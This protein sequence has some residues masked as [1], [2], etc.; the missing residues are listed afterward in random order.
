VCQNPCSSPRQNMSK[1]L[2]FFATAVHDG[3]ERSKFGRMQA[4]RRPNQR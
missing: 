4:S 2:S 1:G 3:Q